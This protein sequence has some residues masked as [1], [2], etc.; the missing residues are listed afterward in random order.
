MEVSFTVRWENEAERTAAA[1]LLRRMA[2]AIDIPSP[3]G[4]AAS[5]DGRPASG[6]RS[7]EGWTASEMV[8]LLQG[9]PEAEAAAVVLLHLAAWRSAVHGGDGI[10]ETEL[11]RRSALDEEG[12][13]RVLD[14]LGQR[15]TA[16]LPDRPD[17]ALTW[18][19][20]SER[21]WSMDPSTAETV[22]VALLRFQALRGGE[23]EPATLSDRPP[24][25]PPPIP[26]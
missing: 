6:D 10:T 13:Y 20:A 19:D 1:A 9:C 4:L 7:G 16:L 25:S 12:L 21:Y 17:L 26:T 23:G 18:T 24:A 22:L 14:A 8:A 5:V 2:E 15:H 3:R 11:C